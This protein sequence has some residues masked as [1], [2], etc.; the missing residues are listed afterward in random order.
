M[1]AVSGLLG[2][3]LWPIAALIRLAK[4]MSGVV[5]L[6]LVDDAPRPVMVRGLGVDAALEGCEDGAQDRCLGKGTGAED[7]GYYRCLCEKVPLS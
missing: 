6:A 2:F 4:W 7:P 3:S 1:S 5:L